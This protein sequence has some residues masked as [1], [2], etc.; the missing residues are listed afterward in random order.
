[1]NGQIKVKTDKKEYPELTYEQVVV[2]CKHMNEGKTEQ[3]AIELALK[4]TA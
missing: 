2:M 4:E 3:E 1:M